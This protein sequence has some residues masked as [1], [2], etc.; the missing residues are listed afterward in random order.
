MFLGKG[1]CEEDG[2]TTGPTYE[3][4][5]RAKNADVKQA[6]GSIKLVIDS[7]AAFVALPIAP[8]T[9]AT[10]TMLGT[11]EN[12]FDVRFTYEDATTDTIVV[13]GLLVMEHDPLNCVTA[14][15]V[16]G[17]GTVQYLIAGGLA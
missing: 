8:G 4:A 15:E 6:L 3:L 12:V 2:V 1:A 9:L 5:L 13:K 17:E 14:V 10:V 11:G 16:Q 7:P